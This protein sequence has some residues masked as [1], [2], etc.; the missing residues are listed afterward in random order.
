MHAELQSTG[1]TDLSVSSRFVLPRG[2]ACGF[3]HTRNS[4][5][6]GGVHTCMGL[7]PGA[8]ACPAGWVAKKHFDM[9]SDYGYWAWCEYQDPYGFCSDLTCI[10]SALS[11]GFTCGV[12]SDTDGTGYGGC[13]GFDTRS[14]CPGGTV[15]APFFDSGRGSGQGV[16]FCYVP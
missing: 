8:G 16:A 5:P 15:R 14:G 11:A 7:D 1:T 13:A 9:S 6:S 12:S 3:H 2:T 10:N 4:P